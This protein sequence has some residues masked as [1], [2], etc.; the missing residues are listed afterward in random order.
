MSYPPTEADV[1]SNDS[2]FSDSVEFDAAE[3]PMVPEDDLGYVEPTSNRKSNDRGL[4]EDEA[5]D[6]NPVPQHI[7]DDEAAAP[8][9]PV[10]NAFMKPR[11]TATKAPQEWVP[12]NLQVPE[13]D[14]EDEFDIST[15]QKP[16]YEDDA[17]ATVGS[18]AQRV[19]FMNGEPDVAGEV[20][21]CFEEPGLLYR[22]VDRPNKTWAFYND[23]RAFEVHVVCTFGKHSKITALENTKMTRDD[24][25]GEYVAE[26][27]VYPGETEPFIKGFVNGFAS[28]LRALPLSEDYYKDRS[29]TQNEQIVQA[30]ID[31]IRAIA[32]DE[33]DAERI[34]QICL[35][36]NLPFVDLSFP[37]VQASIESGASKPFKQL[38]W[39]RPSMYI[40]PELQDQV[41]LFRDG[42]CPGDVEQ[43]ELG[44][45]W[46]MCALATQAEEPKTIMQMFRH[47]KGADLARRERA[48]GAYRV[49]FNK[50]G[51]WR[52]ILVDDYLPVVAGVPTFAHSSDPC[53]LWPAILEKAFAKMHG[54]YAM[55]QSGDP[56]HALTDMSGYP[57]MRIDDAF[58]EATVN[59]GRNVSQKLLAW[60]KKGYLTILTT[61]GKA[62]A[63][64]TD[65]KNAPD[66][67]DQPELET[68]LAGTGLLP[69]HAYSVLDVKE[70]NKG[71]IRLLCVRN[72][73]LYGEGW[74]RA[75]SWEGPEWQQ[76]RDIATACNYAKNRN[77][78]SIVWMS[79]EDALQYFVG[80]GVLFRDVLANDARVP[81]TFADCVPGAVLSVTVKAPTRVTFILSNMDHRGMHVSEVGAAESDPNNMDYPPVMLSLAAPVEGERD[82]YHV[83]A[84]SAVDVTQP[85]DSAWLF[86]QAREIAMMCDLTPSAAP[87]LVIPRLMESEE[88]M[89]G[90]G[91][92]G[93]DMRDL[94]HPIHFF[95]DHAHLSPQSAAGASVKEIAVTVGIATE[96]EI[97]TDVA[98]KLCRMDERNAVFENFPK[99]ETEDVSAQE[100]MYFQ[101]KKAG[102]GYAQEKAGSALY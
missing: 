29:A 26:V 35:E 4:P 19:K 60:Q 80:G 25:T 65:A 56:M 101:T 23:S 55:I 33:T 31:A 37:P 30:E 66:F 79:F 70:F 97:G 88:T 9:P 47:P 89:G 72:P 7:H 5:D 63:I 76:H 28:K 46:L 51:L 86:L 44:D 94:V 54:S 20:T 57:A 52:S 95:N 91:G 27:T 42:I 45:C 92:A 3:K 16:V 8:P 32:G 2:L 74:T 58:A 85:S 83:I 38:P 98:V 22:I 48:I 69:G 96:A 78:R 99:F 11:K 81:M 90:A 13:D 21:N 75:W 77:D 49:S 24:S 62:P 84:N 34:L 43:G 87:Y 82:V 64:S 10:M 50:N 17:P 15:A 12:V 102:C 6:L 14:P 59:G 41:R 93:E 36:N 1:I 53:E 100:E 71:Q 68:A 61:P 39:G 18:G 40:K 67:S 73:W